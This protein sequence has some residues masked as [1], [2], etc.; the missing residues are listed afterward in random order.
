MKDQ[1][2]IDVLLRM[3]EIIKALAY[4]LDNCREALTV[5]QVGATADAMG[6]MKA[7]VES[8]GYM[9]TI[10]SSVIAS[11]RMGPQMNDQQR[12]TQ[13]RRT[14]EAAAAQTAE[15]EQ[16]DEKSGPEI[17]AEAT[18]RTEPMKGT[19]ENPIQ[20]EITDK[21]LAEF[22]SAM[23]GVANQLAGMRTRLDA[24]RMKQDQRSE[25]AGEQL[26]TML[27]IAQL[28]GIQLAQLREELV[29]HAEKMALVG[30]AIQLIIAKRTS[31]AIDEV[32]NEKGGNGEQPK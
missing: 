28:N 24:L 14:Q 30:D 21:A 16:G 17:G 22:T 10:L 15:T 11:E 5:G 31:E 27:S 1:Q 6:V 2:R 26:R 12:R 7:A 8:L 4:T 9:T 18:N 32:N 23:A 20:A 13:E 3:S 19:P 25:D 29:K